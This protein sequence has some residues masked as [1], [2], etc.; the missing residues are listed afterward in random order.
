MGREYPG[1]HG[2]PHCAGDSTSVPL[3]RLEL[4]A[5]LSRCSSPPFFASASQAAGMDAYGLAAC[6]VRGLWQGGFSCPATQHTHAHVQWPCNATH[7]L[8][9]DLPQL[10][11]STAHTRSAHT[12]SP[13]LTRMRTLSCGSPP[14]VHVGRSP[15]G[16]PTCTAHTRSAFTN[17]ICPAA[18]HTHDQHTRL[19]PALPGCAP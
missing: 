6:R 8:S 5:V 11:C 16:A 9:I 7:T 1:G 12:I 19:V 13:G 2:L 4:V 3:F 18:Q 14:H 17:L 10:A 15:G